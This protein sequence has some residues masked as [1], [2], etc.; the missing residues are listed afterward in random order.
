LFIQQSSQ[1]PPI[2]IYKKYFPHPEVFLLNNLQSYSSIFESTNKEYLII[3]SS[4]KI[5]MSVIKNKNNVQHKHQR[6][7]HHH[8]QNPH[9]QQTTTTHPHLPDQQ[10]SAQIV[11]KE[12]FEKPKLF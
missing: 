9:H 4:K 6:I 8:H 2:F 10:P 7:H 5:T 12:G 3:S 11:F 1:I